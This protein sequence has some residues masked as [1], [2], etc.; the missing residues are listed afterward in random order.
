MGVDGII[1]QSAAKFYGARFS[2]L[3]LIFGQDDRL[4]Y[5]GAFLTVMD[6]FCKDHAASHAP[7][8][9]YINRQITVYLLSEM[10]D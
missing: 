3:V 10:K 9:D 4:N 7:L 5:R 1:M 2:T 8:V 6:E